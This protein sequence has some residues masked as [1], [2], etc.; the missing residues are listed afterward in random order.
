MERISEDI[1]ETT[2]DKR[3]EVEAITLP[4]TNI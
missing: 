4:I 2:Q 3:Q 1:E